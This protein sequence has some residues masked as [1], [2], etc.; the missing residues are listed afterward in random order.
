M[1][2]T[3]KPYKRFFRKSLFSYRTCKF[4]YFCTVVPYFEFRIYFRICFAKFSR[5][6]KHCLFFGSNSNKKINL[7]R[8]SQNTKIRKIRSF[9]LPYLALSTC[10]TF[11]DKLKVYHAFRSQTDNLNTGPSPEMFSANKCERNLKNLIWSK[12]SCF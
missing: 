11:K 2:S 12:L 7:F 8:L 6:R 4:E 10:E 9:A 3:F 5:V 1:T